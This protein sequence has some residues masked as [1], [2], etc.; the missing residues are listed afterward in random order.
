MTTNPEEAKDG[1]KFLDARGL[2]SEPI[3]A[4]NIA[5]KL[6]LIDGE[7]SAFGFEKGTCF[8][9]PSTEEKTG[10]TKADEL[11]RVERISGDT[12]DLM[13]SGGMTLARGIPLSD[14]YKILSESDGFKRT[15]KISS[16]SDMVKALT[17]HGLSGDA[18][19]EDGKIVQKL[20]DEHGHEENKEITCFK[21]DKG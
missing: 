5:A 1:K 3:T 12:V 20:K 10:T 15:A 7:G 19:I 21:S 16:E 4:A 6:D 11:W 9:A 14:V 13:D 18:V 8:I 17:S 2:E